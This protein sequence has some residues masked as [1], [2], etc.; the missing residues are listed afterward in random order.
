MRLL[1]ELDRLND[2]NFSPSQAA[3]QQAAEQQLNAGSDVDP[4]AFGGLC[5]SPEPP[6]PPIPPE[7]AS[8]LKRLWEMA[9]PFNQ[10]YQ[11]RVRRLKPRRLQPFFEEQ[12]DSDIDRNNQ[13]LSSEEEFHLYWQSLSFEGCYTQRSENVYEI[14]IVRR[15]CYILIIMFILCVKVEISMMLS[16]I[17]VIVAGQNLPSGMVAFIR[18]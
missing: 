12:A 2:L 10:S 13:T 17:S 16:P 5:L 7:F 8:P 9:S 15:K 4:D 14:G 11:S 18:K 1:Q 6:L 3:D